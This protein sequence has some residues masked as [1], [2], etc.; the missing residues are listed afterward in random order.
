[1][2]RAVLTWI[3]VFAGV[4]AAPARAARSDWTGSAACGTCHPRQLAAWQKTRH[5]TTATRLPAR[6]AARCLA[7]HGTGEAPAGPAIAVEVGCEACHGAGAA[8]AAADLMQDPALAR[9]LGLADVAAPA[10]RTALCA[11]CHRAITTRLEPIDLTA[12][13]H[14]EIR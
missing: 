11:T 10:A 8:Y 1:M 2:P 9:E 5:A 6:P 12:P 7:C 3:A 14:P 4:C 13:A